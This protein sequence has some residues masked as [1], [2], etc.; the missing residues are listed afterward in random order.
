MRKICFLVV[1]TLTLLIPA[2]ASAQTYVR[3][4]GQTPNGPGEDA[5]G[6][7]GSGDVRVL[8]RQYVRGQD[9]GFALTGSDV[10]GLAVIG[11]LLLGTGYAL[12]R[13]RRSGDTPQTA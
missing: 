12:V 4:P 7:G 11:V 10:A 5:G 6:G 2:A 3:P 1:L 13:V 8:G 9:Q